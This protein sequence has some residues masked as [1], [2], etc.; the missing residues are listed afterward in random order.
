MNLKGILFTFIEMKRRNFVKKAGVFATGA[1]LLSLNLPE[2]EKIAPSI[3]IPKSLVMGD[4]IGVTAPAGTIWNDYH[5]RK[6]EKILTE[7]GYRVKI[8][9]SNYNQVAYLAGSDESR[10]AEL[11]EMFKD[12][13]IKAILTMRGGW[14]CARILDLLDYKEVIAN[15]KIIMGFSDITSLVNAIYVKTGL[16]TFHGPCGY[17][18]WGDCTKENVTKSLVD[19]SPYVM[20]NPSE[21]TLEL[22]TLTAGKAQGRLVGGNLTVIQSMLGTDYEPIWDNAIFFMEETNEEPYRIDRML[23]HFKQHGVFEKVKGVVIGS[24]NKCNPEEP[25][26]S[27]SLNEVFDQHFKNVRFPVYQGASF[28]HLADKFTLPIGVMAEIDADNFTITTLGKSVLQ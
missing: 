24:F 10:A 3:K 11:M 19:G 28:G 13:S 12:S 21:S 5:I 15:P 18:S 27:F 8:G 7:M 20:K 4:L 26:K 16:I 2:T 1:G 9:Q 17:S 14:G 6:I 23:W 22:R 25:E